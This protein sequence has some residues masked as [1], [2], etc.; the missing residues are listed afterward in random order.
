MNT[1]HPSEHLPATSTFVIEV[2]EVT[3]H[4]LGLSHPPISVS[5]V[6]KGMLSVPRYTTMYPYWY[7]G[8]EVDGSC[9]EI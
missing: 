5:V 6:A 1:S 4:Q 7:P 8:Y 9:F 3:M 2:P